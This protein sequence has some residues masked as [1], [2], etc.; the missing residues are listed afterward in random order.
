MPLI[1]KP[2][3]A[4]GYFVQTIGWIL[5]LGCG[6]AGFFWSWR[7]IAD[8]VSGWVAFIAFILFPVVFAFAPLIAW[9]IT[10]IF[11]LGIFILWLVSWVGGT[12]VVAGASMRK[13]QGMNW[14]Q[15]HLNWAWIFVYLVWFVSNAATITTPFSIPSIIGLAFLLVV[16]G[17]VIKQKGRSLWWLLL[18]PV[19][20]PLWLKNM[21]GKPEPFASSEQGEQVRKVS[22]IEVLVVDDHQVVRDG[23]RNMFRNEDDITIVGEAPNGTE[24]L[25]KV[26]SLA[27]DIVLTNI[28]MPGI[29]GI[30]FTRQ[31]KQKYPSC[32]VIMLTLYDEYLPQAMEAGASGYL[33][34]DIQSKE[35]V[36]AIRQVYRGQVVISKG[37]QTKASTSMEDS[38]WM[39][40]G[41]SSVKGS[42]FTTSEKDFLATKDDVTLLGMKDT[43]KKND[44]YDKFKDKGTETGQ[45]NVI[46]CPKCGALDTRPDSRFCS[47]CG[48]ELKGQ[49]QQEQVETHQPPR[50]GYFELCD[51]AQSLHHSGGVAN[52]QKA[53]SLYKRAIE[54][55][56]D[57]PD[58]H[59]G[60][61]LIHYDNALAI[62]RD[63][64][65]VPGG[66]WLMFADE[67]SPE[68]EDKFSLTSSYADEHYGNRKIAI[69]EL[70]EAAR[71]T[72]DMNGKFRSDWSEN[73]KLRA[74]NMAAEIHCIIDIEEGVKAYENIL[75]IAPDYVP[76]HFCLASCYAETYHRH[77]Q[78]P[79]TSYYG[80]HFA[81]NDK[82]AIKEYEFIKQHA[83]Q[84]T[85]DLESVLAR[86]GVKIK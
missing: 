57:F 41:F 39:N 17:W 77:K 20:S 46:R 61:G 1:Q 67:K 54:M 52:D 64:S 23:I 15:R 75:K 82:L 51:S 81:S 11:P 65:A 13:A 35:L 44:D 32:K 27:P 26:E 72:T 4:I 3:T 21:K 59:A 12:L 6:L 85:S 47:N 9:F 68:N 30:E 69:K 7:I 25:D 80:E 63:Y 48:V 8:A 37:V 24:G 29:D 83:P 38:G 55:N 5:W 86:N 14:F 10:G 19:F 16:S 73:G 84:L 36:Q 45:K 76:A 33:L 58:A 71:L 50:T 31:V 28:K 42:S 60:L 43:H 49:P 34:K 2:R 22:A 18:M 74:L 56:P 66:S 53:V 78:S 40:E 70:E 79:L 62:E